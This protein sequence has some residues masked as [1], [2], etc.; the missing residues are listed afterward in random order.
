[1]LELFLISQFYDSILLNGVY[2][3][4]EV[5][6]EKRMQKLTSTSCRTKTSDITFVL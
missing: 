2:G 6:Y 5:G 1:M 4:D 3:F